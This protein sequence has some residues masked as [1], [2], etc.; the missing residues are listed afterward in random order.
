[1]VSIDKLT[2]YVEN[3]LNVALNGLNNQ[4][5]ANVEFRLVTD[6]G[7]LKESEK[8]LNVV[9]E[10]VNGVV[11]AGISDKVILAGGLTIFTIPLN[12]ELIVKLEDIED[13]GG[14]LQLD[15]D[16][17]TESLSQEFIGNIEK[18]SAIREVLDTAFGTQYADTILDDDNNAFLVTVVSQIAQNERRDMFG[19]LG[20]AV[21][22]NLGINFTFVESGVNSQNTT[23]K[24]NGV[25]IPYTSISITKVKNA[26][27]NL[28][29]TAGGEMVGIPVFS[30]LT[31]SA[32]IPALSGNT[33]TTKILNEILQEDNLS[34]FYVLTVGIDG[35]DYSFLANV[36]EAT[37]TAGGIQNVGLSVTLGRAPTF[38]EL[39]DLSGWQVLNIASNQ[40]QTKAI[41][42]IFRNKQ[43]YKISFA[44]A[45]V[46]LTG[47]ILVYKE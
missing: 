21:T 3:K 46:L 7:L 47:D 40:T 34:I 14:V 28:F 26:D 8:N 43:L 39:L 25:D 19:T 41:S 22:F 44:T 13:N 31:V 2:Q 10:F 29:S 30:Q 15:I 42:I 16:A 33:V 4:Y 38:Y 5:L 32:D 27:Q 9:T 35:V 36:I 1:M 24:L 18:L 12:I 20:M 6:T 37:G 17:N 23:F 45:E 11:K